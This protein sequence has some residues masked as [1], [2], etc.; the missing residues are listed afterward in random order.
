M[1]VKKTKLVT[2]K[3]QET[4]ASVD[5]FIEKLSDATKKKRLLCNYRNDEKGH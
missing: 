1:P 2:I 3:T 4:S 5:S